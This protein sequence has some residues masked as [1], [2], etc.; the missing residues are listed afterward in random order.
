MRLLFNAVAGGLAH[1]PRRAALRLGRG[2]GTFFGAVIRYRRAAAADAL[3]RSLPELSAGARRRL[4]DAMYR[5][6]FANGVEVLRLAGGAPDNPLELVT[7]EGEEH[8]RAARQRGRGVLILTA[9]L[10]NFELLAMFAARRGY[11]LTIVT[12][13]FKSPVINALWNR[14]RGKHGVQVVYSHHALRACLKA[15]QHDGLLGFILDQN[16]PRGQ[17]VFVTFF[18]RPACT[19]PGLAFLAAVTQAPVV[20]AFIHRTAGDRHHLRVLPALEPPPDR[21]EESLRRATQQY[22]TLIEQEIRRYPDQ[23]FWVHRRWKTQ[24]EPGDVVAA[25]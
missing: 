25:P 16:R 13:Q 11:P 24:P 5:S 18:G 19:T 3:R 23:W 14:V 22:T 10:G 7:F 2:L 4:V 1:L 9:H 8:V 12:K 21:S 17:G 20:P 15:L 6:L